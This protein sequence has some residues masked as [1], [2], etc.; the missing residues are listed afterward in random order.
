MR[1]GLCSQ[2]FAL[3]IGC[4]HDSSVFP[5]LQDML[6]WFGVANDLLCTESIMDHVFSPFD[7]LHFIMRTILFPTALNG[8]QLTERRGARISQRY[9][10]ECFSGFAD[11][12][13]QA[14]YVSPTLS[15]IV[16]MFC[17]HQACAQALHCTH[18][19]FICFRHAVF[20]IW[21]IALSHAAPNTISPPIIR[22]S[23]HVGVHAGSHFVAAPS[24]KAGSKMRAAAHFQAGASGKHQPLAPSSGTGI[25]TG[26]GSGSGSFIAGK[27]SVGA[28]GMTMVLEAS[29]PS[30]I[31]MG[32]NSFGAK[33]SKGQIHPHPTALGN[34]AKAAAPGTLTM[35]ALAAHNQALQETASEQKP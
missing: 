33:S 28:A 24:A 25:G 16:L 35:E 32:S 14:S 27:A 17:I 1:Y 20:S 6:R 30:K 5:L 2:R 13:S 22:S 7:P 26:S 34:A 21:S 23:A 8:P 15:V 12:R 19:T 31:V 10:A 9:H 3:G 11:P 29:A 18:S 4:T